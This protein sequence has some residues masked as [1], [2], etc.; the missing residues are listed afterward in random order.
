MFKK[1]LLLIFV[2]LMILPLISSPPP[3]TSEFV[4]TEGFV[5]VANVQDYYKI[6]E[7]AEV[8][9]YVFNKSN[10]VLLDGT[11]VSC[12]VELTDHNGTVVLSGNP[13]IEGNHFHMSRPPN[14]VSSADTYGLTIV[15]NDST[16]AG[17]KTAF[18]EANTYGEG[19]TEGRSLNF[20]F[21]MIFLMILFLMA[22]IG[23][24]KVEHYV[25][26][27]ACYWVAH[28]LFIVGTFSLWQ[29]NEGYTLATSGLLGVFKVLFYVSIISMFP[30]IL[31]SLAWIFWIHVTTD[32]VRGMMEKGMTSEEA[33]SR[34]SKKGWFGL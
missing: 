22:L 12:A 33:W 4:G 9:I 3:I 17:Y 19:L 15:C 16:L 21:G 24:F 26:K 13:T 32:E 30:M 25:G 8:H 6:N 7:G 14:I 18:F 1:L 29:F 20:N 27:F 2:F 5:I 31:L 23:A 11:L 10:G 34:T 28:L